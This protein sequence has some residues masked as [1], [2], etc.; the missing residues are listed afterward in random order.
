MSLLHSWGPS[1]NPFV[2]AITPE[3]YNRLASVLWATFIVV[4][5]LLYTWSLSLGDFVGFGWL[6]KLFQPTTWFFS[7]VASLLIGVLVWRRVQNL[8]VR[9]R[10][11]RTRFLALLDFLNGQ[12]LASALWHSASSVILGYFYLRQKQSRVKSDWFL[13]PEGK[14]GAPELNENLVFIAG[15]CLFVALA[16][17]GY[18]RYAE[19]DQ[20]A[21]PP[22]QRGLHWR[23]RARLPVSLSTAVSLGTIFLAVYN[24]LYLICGFSLYKIAAAS[25]VRIGNFAA[26]FGNKSA[27]I[28]LIIHEGSWLRWIGLRSLLHSYLTG[29]LLLAIWEAVDHIFEVFFTAPIRKDIPRSTVLTGLNLPTGQYA[30]YLAWLTLKG[31]LE[32]RGQSRQ[33][34]FTVRNDEPSP[35]KAVLASSMSIVDRLSESL[36][37]EQKKSKDRREQEDAK[38]IKPIAAASG[39][40]GSSVF[41]PQK[42]KQAI[43][44]VVSDKVKEFVFQPGS[45]ARSPKV[46]P[47][48]P[49]VLQDRWPQEQHREYPALLRPPRQHLDAQQTAGSTAQSQSIPVSLKDRRAT[50]QEVLANLQQWIARWKWGKWLVAETLDRQ[51]KDLFADFQV[52]VWAIQV[53]ISIVVASPTEDRFGIVSDELDTILECLLRCQL[54]LE[55]RLAD[56]PVKPDEDPWIRNQLGDNQLL[57]REPYALLQ[58]MQNSLYRVV[59]AWYET[60]GQRKLQPRYAR[61]FQRYLDFRE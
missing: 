17:A 23:I 13:Y 12:L 10:V 9:R 2:E 59:T 26:T 56:P 24:S 18:R 50:G 45:P 14:Y 7:F 41:S 5:T 55:T 32:C 54:G 30:Q 39:I 27:P 48:P 53:L 29:M 58:V 11:Q 1:S 44:D 51:T 31:Q 60:L 33:S 15:Y 36:E 21:F 28:G 20:L 16:Y 4:Y 57:F 25:I 42:R 19:R 8:Q 61:K 6:R 37:V 3:L 38:R 40:T 43:L 47:E 22:I 52:Q 34:I 49:K 46:P 35:L